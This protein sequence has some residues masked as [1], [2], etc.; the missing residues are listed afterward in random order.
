MSS[1]T[2]KKA[3]ADHMN[4]GIPSYPIAAP[5]FQRTKIM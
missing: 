3:S 5:D 2:R 1:R 4:Q